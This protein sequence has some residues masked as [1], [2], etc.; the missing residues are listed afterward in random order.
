MWQFIVEGKMWQFIIE[1][2]WLMFP[3][4]LFSIFALAIVIEKF[5]YFSRIKVNMPE[6]LSQILTYARKNR[7]REAIGVCEKSPSYLANILK[8]GL[9]RYDQSKEIIKEAMENASLYEIPK[10][11]KN[12]NFLS[13]LAHIAPLLGLLGTVVGLVGCFA[14]IE[15]Y[16]INVGV[17]N[18]S[19][20]AGGIRVALH[21]TVAG[22][23]VAIPSSLIYN[24]FIHRVSLYVLS[25]ERASTE[26]LEVLS[27]GSYRNEV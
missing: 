20:L 9:F 19:D 2:G 12:L 5:I 18:P 13:T 24:Y 16:A 6:L 21:T 14:A 27:E 8:A 23:C 15:K 1:G 7:I 26:L 4:I 3:I 17:V 10:L 11:E 22:L 25:A